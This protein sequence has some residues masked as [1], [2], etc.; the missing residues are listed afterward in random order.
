MIKHTT[1]SYKTSMPMTTNKPFSVGSL[2]GISKT[3]LLVLSGLAHLVRDRLADGQPSMA[4]TGV[5]RVT[6][7]CSVCPSFSS[8]LAQVWPS[9]NGRGENEQ[10][11]TC[12]TSVA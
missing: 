10:K 6:L 11:D 9:D 8:R 3:A 12:G 2:L 4:S 5:A 1:N 7:P